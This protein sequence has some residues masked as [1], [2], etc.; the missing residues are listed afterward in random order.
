MRG[1]KKVKHESVT[2]NKQEFEQAYIAED[3]CR[4]HAD[5]FLVLLS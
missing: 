4:V 5:S 3:V 2:L 1:D